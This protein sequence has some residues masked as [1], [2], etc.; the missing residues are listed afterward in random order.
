VARAAEQTRAPHAG[1]G[2]GPFEVL[3]HTAAAS[4]DDSAAF[5]DTWLVGLLDFAG[6]SSPL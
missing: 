5:F 4:A 3:D 6:V 1:S 2:A